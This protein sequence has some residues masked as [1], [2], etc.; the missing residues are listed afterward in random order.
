MVLSRCL[1]RLLAPGRASAMEQSLP[2]VWCHF[3]SKMQ[4]W[5][6]GMLWRISALILAV[7]WLTDGY[8]GG[9]DDPAFGSVP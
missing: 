8:F 1:K 2:S 3:C 5:V 9:V 4:C 6:G 7:W